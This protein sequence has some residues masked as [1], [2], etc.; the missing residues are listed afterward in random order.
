[1]SVGNKKDLE[2]VKLLQM[3]IENTNLYKSCEANLL[4]RMIEIIHTLYF[5]DSNAHKDPHIA[6]QLVMLY[7]GTTSESQQLLLQVLYWM[8]AVVNLNSALN[9][10]LYSFKQDTHQNSGFLVSRL[11]NELELSFS[12]RRFGSSIKYIPLLLKFDITPISSPDRLDANFDKRSVPLAYDPWF[13]LP[14]I[15]DMSLR[16]LMDLKQLATN[17]CIGYVIMC[18]SGSGQVYTMARQVL[19]QLITMAETSRY[20]ERDLLRLLLYKVHYLCEDFEVAGQSGK[21]PHAVRAALANLVSVV[22]NPGH[23]LFEQAI[24][25]ITQAPFIKL[26]DTPQQMEIP[27]Y[28]TLIPSTDYNNYVKETNWMINVLLMGLLSDEDV[29]M[30]ERQFVFETVQTVAGSAYAAKST[31]KLVDELL[32]KAKSL[33]EEE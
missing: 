26:A 1:M 9:A 28:R 17:H 18:L 15:M 8:D 31:K 6:S 29:A 12:G 27:L 24:R 13:A 21:I 30:Y 11:A 19:L 16:Q 22:I 4:S 33:C 7:D 25:Y 20:R 32:V 10:T 2:Y 14:A 3:I 5:C 23:F